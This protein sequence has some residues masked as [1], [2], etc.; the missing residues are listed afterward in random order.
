M[1]ISTETISAV[2]EGYGGMVDNG[3][4]ERGIELARDPRSIITKNYRTNEYRISVPS[5]SAPTGYRT[6]STA[7]RCTCYV[8]QV[9]Q[10]MCKHEVAFDLMCLQLDLDNEFNRKLQLATQAAEASRKPQ[11]V[12]AGLE[13]LFS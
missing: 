1:N 2:L 11:P 13:A 8:A 4:L 10:T 5:K 3:T 12:A 9:Q 6:V 7:E